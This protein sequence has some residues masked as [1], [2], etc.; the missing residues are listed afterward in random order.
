MTA[1]PRDPPAAV[2]GIR[3]LGT[4]SI[5][6][7][8]GDDARFPQSGAVS[9]KAS[10][11]GTPG[12]S[13][14]YTA[15]DM[16]GNVLTARTTIGVTESTVTSGLFSFDQVVSLDQFIAS[17]D[18][19]DGQAPAIELISTRHLLR[20]P[21]PP[22]SVTAVAGDARAT[23]SFTP[24][25]SGGSAVTYTVT[26]TD[27]TNSAHGGQTITTPY[28]TVT[29][30]GLT[31]GENYTFTVHA[32]SAVG[33]STESAASNT[34]APQPV[35]TV[36][37]APRN[38]VANPGDAQAVVTFDP[39]IS[40]GGSA[41]TSYRVSAIDET[42]GAHG[43]QTHTGN[44]PNTITGLTNG[45]FYHFT[46]RAT[47]AIGN[48]AESV[49]SNT[50]KPLAVVGGAPIATFT[51]YFSTS[52]KLTLDA[53]GSNGTLTWEIDGVA[54]TDTDTIITYGP[55]KVGTHHVKLTAVATGSTTTERDI[56]V[57]WIAEPMHLA[58]TDTV[59]GNPGQP[60]GPLGTGLPLLAATPGIGPWGAVQQLNET[61]AYPTYG[62]NMARVI[63]NVDGSISML[64]RSAD[65]YYALPAS[66]QPRGQKYRACL[67]RGSQSGQL[68]NTRH[69]RAANAYL[70]VS[71]ISV[72]GNLTLATDT[73]TTRFY[74][75][76]YMPLG[77][78][79]DATHPP[80]YTNT[81]KTLDNINN[82]TENA[83][84]GISI[85]TIPAGTTN[86][87]FFGDMSTGLSK[88]WDARPFQYDVWQNLV[89]EVKMSPDPTIGY[90]RLYHDNSVVTTNVPS[91]T[92]L[93][94][95]AD[96][97]KYFQSTVKLD[98]AGKPIPLVWNLEVY[99]TVQTIQA[100]LDGG[101]TYP[102]V[103]VKFRNVRVGPTLNSVSTTN[104]LPLPTVVSAS[105][106]SVA[107]S[108]T[109]TVQVTGTNFRSHA[110]GITADITAPGGITT[111]ITINS[112]TF[113]SSTRVDVN[114]T[115][116]S[117]APTGLRWVTVTN[118]TGG[119]DAQP[120]LTIT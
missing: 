18:E 90:V 71:D 107:R 57:P 108:A 38:I 60:S 100:I 10:Y 22:T 103:T 67:T 13:V 70:A 12:A 4:A 114:I 74:R 47:N 104:L 77:T 64:T 110:P 33:T 36:P 41:I 14:F 83:A 102:D 111:G 25:D 40:D 95:G 45:E 8:P 39:P 69:G 75:I 32:T 30:L 11:I 116:A 86:S 50:V 81:P 29:L 37:G 118:P 65:V 99:R 44:S 112:V 115:V 54:Q 76:E 120:I 117:T 56:D 1:I 3:T 17:W 31:N 89:L 62:D 105:P 7:A 55:L 98:T 49:V 46:V 82:F 23:I 88:N 84:G 119:V 73:P 72:Q 106:S 97:G 5:Q 27:L 78:N 19:N 87:V 16:S 48:S 96:L 80:G 43:G 9:V 58:S 15:Y 79:A 20:I 61:E 26:A 66:I 52:S 85:F 63:R 6:A 2:P 34:V 35:T 101:G 42:N 21:S 113:N 24:G 93:T 109:Q 51:N 92:I 28:P 94:P 59:N 53:T 91:G 68:D